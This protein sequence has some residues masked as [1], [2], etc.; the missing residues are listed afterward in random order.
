[1]N[2][3]DIAKLLEDQIWDD[4]RLICVELESGIQTPPLP[5]ISYKFTT[6]FIYQPTSDTHAYDGANDT[7]VLKQSSQPLMTLSVTVYATTKAAGLGVAMQLKDWFDFKAVDYLSEHNIVVVR[8]DNV[9]DR[10]V[11]QETFYESRVGFDVQLRV[12]H[13]VIRSTDYIETVELKGE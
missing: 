4:L 13:E 6:P 1:M 9:G 12:S 2:H 11:L 3:A 10:T 7:V 5:F 8:T